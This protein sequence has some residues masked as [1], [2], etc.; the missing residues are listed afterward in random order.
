MK[1]AA[2]LLAG[3]PFLASCGGWEEQWKARG[4]CEE[5]LDRIVAA[6][7]AMQKPALTASEQRQI[8]SELFEGI[9]Q[10]RAAQSRNSS[11]CFFYKPGKYKE[12]GTRAAF[13]MTDPRVNATTPASEPP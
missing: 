11:G 3:L 12:A 10:I 9:F 4:L 7:A 1:R 5:G 8:R 13:L 2:V 6:E